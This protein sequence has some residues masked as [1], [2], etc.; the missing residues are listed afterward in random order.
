MN[1]GETLITLGAMTLLV[2]VVL[3]MNRSL[4]TTDTFLNETRFGLETT[5]IATSYIEEISQYPFD[6]V[7]W[8]TT[9]TS[10]TPADFTLAANLGPE[11]G[12]T[13]VTLFDDLDDFN[14]YAVAETTQ[15]NVYNIQVQ[16]H[17]VD[18]NTP[19]VNTTSCTYYKKLTIV[20]IN[21]LNNETTQMNYV[22]GFWYF[23]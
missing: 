5:A 16:V 3:N 22:H 17:Y 12:E 2:V 19:D 1:M 10:K 18:G 20:I 4:N 6:E 15:Q 23:N 21:M 13:D 7:S 14:N 9:M 11:S 8:D